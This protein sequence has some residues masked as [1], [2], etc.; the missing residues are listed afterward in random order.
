M[1]SKRVAVIGAGA[2]GLTA[3]KCCLDEGLTPVCFER[4]SHIGG[5]WHYTDNPIEGQA[6]VMKSTVINTSKEMMCYSDFPIPAHY[7]NFMHNSQVLEYFQQYSENFGLEKYINYETEVLHVKKADDF[8]QTGQWSISY[9]GT[10]SGADSVEETFDGVLVCTGHHAEKYVPEFPGLKDYQGKVYLSTRRGSWVLNRVGSNGIPIDLIFGR[11]PT[12]YLKSQFPFL[13][14]KFSEFTVNR[15]FNHELYSL[16][17][18]HQIWSQHP[19]VNDDL[20]NRLITGSIKV[21]DDVKRFTQQGVEFVDGT[22]EDNIDAVILA[23]GYSFGFP[24]LAKEVVGVKENRV[25]LYKL[26]YPPD[27]EKHT[28][29]VIGC[30]QPLGAVMPISEMQCRLATRVIKGT[31]Q[32]PPWG[33]I[34]SDVRLREAEMAQQYVTSR[35]HTI[36]VEYMGYMDEL[37]VLVGCKP[38]FAALFKQDPLFS[39]KVWFG[40]VYPYT[41]RLCG[42]GQNKDAKQMILT[43]WER[44]KEPLQTRPMGDTLSSKP[45]QLKQSFVW[46]LVAFVVYKIFQLLSF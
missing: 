32:L 4:T 28:L 27:L 34:W 18:K 44:I 2:S 35:R 25:E 46:F 16:R 45:S 41:Y 3:I 5:L 1:T 17:P 10:T 7:P 33:E 20:P 42:P 43:T 40:P 24:F 29:A 15:R 14:S 8:S 11:R 37:A 30:I 6:C 26:M 22:R 21:K 19:M 39:L 9:R 13:S 31:T 38:D 23:T 12:L 36:Q